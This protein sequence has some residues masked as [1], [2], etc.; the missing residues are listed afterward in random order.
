M[1]D[2]NELRDRLEAV[3]AL[4]YSVEIEPSE[5]VCAECSFR[6]PNG[7]YFGNIVEYPCPTV[8]ALEG[9]EQG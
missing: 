6:L 5:S 2:L 7:H 8:S 3:K 4:H 9:G 1:T